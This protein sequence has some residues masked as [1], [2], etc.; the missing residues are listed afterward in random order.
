MT[1]RAELKA[2]V[3]TARAQAARRRLEGLPPGEWWAEIRDTAIKP[4]LT[5]AA[6][7]LKEV[8]IGGNYQRLNGGS[9][10]EL[11]AGLS[12]DRVLTFTHVNDEI[13][14]KSSGGDLDETWNDRSHVTRET[15]RKTV[16]AFLVLVA[17]DYPE[18]PQE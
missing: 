3:T 6:A 18:E 15:V 7:I 16:L 2:A 8:G 1:F 4:A 5:D 9:G 12:L 14:V 13:Q 10:M 11:R 17:S